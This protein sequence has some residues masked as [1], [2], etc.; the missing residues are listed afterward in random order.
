[1]GAKVPEQHGR[2]ARHPREEDALIALLLERRSAG[3]PSEIQGT[4]GVETKEVRVVIRDV[5]EGQ[6]VRAIHT[7][8][9]GRHLAGRSKGVSGAGVLRRVHTHGAV[10]EVH[11]HEVIVAVVIHVGRDER[12]A[13]V[14]VARIH[15]A[16]GTSGSETLPDEV[17]VEARVVVRAVGFPSAEQLTLPV[18]VVVAQL[19]EIRVV[20]EG[21]TPDGAVGRATEAAARARVRL[22]LHGTGGVGVLVAED[23]I[24][25]SVSVH[26]LEEGGRERRRA[27][28]EHTRGGFDPARGIA[29]ASHTVALVHVGVGVAPR[30]GDLDDVVVGITVDVP[31]EP[32]LV[33]AD[34][35]RT[36]L[37]RSQ[38]DERG[39]VSRAVRVV[40]GQ[41]VVGRPLLHRDHVDPV[42]VRVR[43]VGAGARITRPAFGDIGTRSTE[44]AD[45]VGTIRIVRQRESPTNTTARIG[46][47]VLLGDLDGGVSDSR[48]ERDMTV[49]A[50]GEADDITRLRLGRILPVFVLAKAIFA[51]KNVDHVVTVAGVRD[52]VEP[53]DE[54]GTLTVA[55]PRPG[56]GVVGVDVDTIE[57]INDGMSTVIAGRH[58]LFHM[59]EHPEDE[60]HEDEDSAL[61]HTPLY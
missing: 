29:E 52:V 3:I 13:R 49:G 47:P 28:R 11:P 2:R 8:H 17:A 18:V 44:V 32:C 7:T 40:A 37:E 38:A 27:A 10:V 55:T 9:V 15:R 25:I 53:A 61:H 57:G 12:I 59:R 42:V 24:G 16:R 56:I 48:H 33:R 45:S 22:P 1:M 30:V 39:G 43:V 31:G 60:R 23:E 6:V 26:V 20:P 21:R 35:T 14:A 36:G 58:G 46:G 50:V 4:R 51:L 34:G 19:E 5:E 41:R 54:L